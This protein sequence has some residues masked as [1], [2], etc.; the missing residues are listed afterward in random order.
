M[1]SPELRPLLSIA[2]WSDLRS[3]DFL[4]KLVL[5]KHISQRI[6]SRSNERKQKDDVISNVRTKTVEG[7]V[8][9]VAKEAGLLCVSVTHPGTV[10][11][12][13]LGGEV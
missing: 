6:G 7:G 12:P 3:P 1:S 11:K 10:T 13:V 5:G 4:Q 2:L 8:F 9:A